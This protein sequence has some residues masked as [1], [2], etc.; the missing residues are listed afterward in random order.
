MPLPLFLQLTTILSEHVAPQCCDAPSTARLSPL[1]NS[2]PGTMP[3]LLPRALEQLPVVRRCTVMF[4]PSTMSRSDRTIPTQRH[5]SV[6]SR[7]PAAG[8][9]AFLK[10]YRRSHTPRE[11]IFALA[12]SVDEVA[13]FSMVYRLRPVLESRRTRESE[14]CSLITRSQWVL[15]ISVTEKLHSLHFA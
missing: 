8:L 15:R 4:S 2:H 11:H 5:P 13:H 1:P 3:P 14:A 7:C 9:E 12:Q 6:C 10:Q